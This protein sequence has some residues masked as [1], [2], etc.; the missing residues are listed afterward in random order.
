MEFVFQ[1]H[2]TSGMHCWGMSDMICS[3]ISKDCNVYGVAIRKSE[4][5]FVDVFQHQTGMRVRHK[6]RDT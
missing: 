5:W 3:R 2:N 1:L 4:W 6:G